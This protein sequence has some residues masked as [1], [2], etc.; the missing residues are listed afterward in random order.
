MEQIHTNSVRENIDK[1]Q[2]AVYPEECWEILQVLGQAVISR[3]RCEGKGIPLL[4]Q[5]RFDV[6]IKK[7]RGHEQFVTV[8]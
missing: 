3:R 1:P 5:E 8:S 2:T 7:T 6:A 4:R